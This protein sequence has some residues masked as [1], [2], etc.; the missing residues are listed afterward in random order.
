VAYLQ[1]AERLGVSPSHCVAIEDSTAGISSAKSA[2]MH[3]IG[4]RVGNRYGQDQSHAHHVVETLFDV[5]TLL[6]G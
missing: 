3:C 4:V 2:G 1:A 5:A 6:L